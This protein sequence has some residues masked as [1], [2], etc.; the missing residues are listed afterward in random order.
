M[1]GSRAPTTGVAAIAAVARGGAA[2]ALTGVGGAGGWGGGLD[3]VV[4]IN[5]DIVSKGVSF[6][7]RSNKGISS[8]H[9]G[10]TAP[11]EAPVLLLPP[12]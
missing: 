8:G 6:G 11:P 2:F 9:G 7:R 5:L 12:P 10:G 3:M 1:V 4:C